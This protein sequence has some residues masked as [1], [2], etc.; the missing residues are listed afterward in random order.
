MKMMK[1]FLVI[2]CIVLVSSMVYALV[3]PINKFGTK[4]VTVNPTNEK[5]AQNEF[6]VKFNDVDKI[7]IQNFNMKNKVAEISSNK[8]SG[9]KVLKVPKGKTVEQMVEI[10]NEN[11]NVKFAEP[12]YI[13]YAMMVP[14]DKYYSYQWHLDNPVYGGIHAEAAWDIST[15]EGVVVAVLDT[16]VA[17]DLSDSPK[18]FVTGWNFI[19][20]NINA[21]DDNGHGSHV[22]GTIA[23]DTNNSIGVA[24]V[25]FDACIMP[26]KVLDENGSGSYDGIIEGIYYATDNGAEI[27][28]MSLGG[29]SGSDAMS[30]ALEYAYNKNITIIV[31]AGNSGRNTFNYPAAYDDYVIAVGAT[32]YNERLAYYSSYYTITTNEIIKEYVDITAPGGDIRRDLNRDGFGDGVLQQTLEGFYFY[33]GTSMAAPH[34]SGVAAL[35]ISQLKENNEVV[36]PTRIR[37]ILQTT[38]EDKGDAGWDAK[39]GSGIVDAHAALLWTPQEPIDNDGD[40][41]VVPGDCDDN[42]AST[43]PGAD[44][45][46]E[47][48][49]DNNCNG[50][51]DEDCGNVPPATCDSYCAGLTSY[52]SGECKEKCHPRKETEISS[53][54]FTC[55]GT[56]VCCCR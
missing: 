33:Q 52:S 15:G 28:S 34:V 1:T 29:P 41:Y 46:C 53:K 42:N 40:G 8:Q 19:R 17:H 50:E 49:I 23:Q 3:S 13:A 2:L 47:D 32:T 24:G 36:T 22:A 27:I 56:T 51:T 25:A 55:E 7:K 4:T 54:E 9:F 5:Y 21:Y 48:G 37:E 35:V 14:N 30:E 18:C 43:N 45:I 16:G 39:F 10:Y 12:N 31:S 38:A 11:P 20:N 44:E 6:I 26:V